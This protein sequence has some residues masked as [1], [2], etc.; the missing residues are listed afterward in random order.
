MRPLFRRAGVYFGLR[1]RPHK[2]KG[3]DTST[4][5]ELSDATPGTA[6]P[7]NLAWNCSRVVDIQRSSESEARAPFGENLPSNQIMVNIDLEQN[8]DVHR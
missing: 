2:L 4:M 3:E 8:V 1:F 5:L 6:S 7:P